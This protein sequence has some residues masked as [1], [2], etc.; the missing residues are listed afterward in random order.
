MLLT[1]LAASDGTRMAKRFVRSSGSVVTTPYPLVKRFWSFTRNA[2]D[3]D[4]LYALLVTHGEAGHCLLKGQL[5]RPLRHESRAGRT[6]PNA[7]TDLL[8]LDLD[9]DRGFADIAAFLAAIGLGGVSYVLHHSSSAGIT[10]AIGLRAHGFVRLATPVAPER[11]KLWL[12]HMNL[13]VPGLREQVG[14]SAN[15]MTLSYPLDV[16]SCQ[17]DKL[18]FIADPVVERLED[19][20]AGRR[21]VLNMRESGSADFRFDHLHPDAVQREPDALVAELRARAG[22][23]A[24]DPRYVALPGRERL[25]VNPEP[26][27]VTGVRRSPGFVYLNLNGGDSWA[28]Y[29]PES[30][31]E[32]LYSFKGEPPMRLADI[33]PGLWEQVRPHDPF[34]AVA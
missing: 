33:A 21:F 17:N 3:L 2:A 25:L 24:R 27:A 8:V 5:D 15:G 20:L 28:Y 13:R 14:L 22:L 11:L 29:F 19:P 34:A 32:L 16:T 31:P 7:P 6:D 18:L 26:A 10:S 12:R 23:P 1:L 30:N 4:Q 9:T